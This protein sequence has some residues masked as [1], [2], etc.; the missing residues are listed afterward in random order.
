MSKNE[1]LDLIRAELDA[2]V[3]RAVAKVAEVLDEREAQPSE[4]V[5][6]KYNELIFAVGRKYGGE[7]RHQTAL[8][9]IRQAEAP[10]PDDCK[11]MLAAA[12]KGAND[13]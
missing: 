12:P 9:Y 10:G 7:T 8:R 1:I 2:A 13:E 3:D 4:G 11:A 6:T 5:R